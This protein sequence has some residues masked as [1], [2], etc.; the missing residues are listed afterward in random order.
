[1]SSNELQF[2]NNN[3]GAVQYGN[4]INYYEFNPPS[5]RITLLPSHIW[6]ATPNTTEDT[7]LALDIGCN[8]GVSIFKLSFYF[9]ISTT[10][11]F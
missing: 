11:I 5:N 2:K 9:K 3:P 6:S 7:F 10:L 4:F 1:M 8:A